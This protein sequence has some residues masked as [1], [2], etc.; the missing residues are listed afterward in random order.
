MDAWKPPAAA[1]LETLTG[2]RASRPSYLTVHSLDEAFSTAV[3]SAIWKA[4]TEWAMT[5]RVQDSLSPAAPV[6]AP[7]WKRTGRAAKQQRST[8][9]FS[10]SV[11][12]E[13]GRV[14]VTANSNW[15]VLR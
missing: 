15:A 3:A 1:A 12:G 9:L 5:D 11:V 4:R 13:A 8:R 14:A 6:T 10:A 2:R 7:L